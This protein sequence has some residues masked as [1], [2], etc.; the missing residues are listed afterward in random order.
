MNWWWGIKRGL[1]LISA[2]GMPTPSHLFSKMP[3]QNPLLKFLGSNYA[4]SRGISF[5]R[6]ISVSQ[7]DR[8]T[9]IR[10]QSL[11]GD[12]HGLAAYAKLLREAFLPGAVVFHL[13]LPVAVSATRRP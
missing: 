12:L 1:M 9:K 6:Q 10:R 5:F 13:S 8:R 11:A 2:V 3:H 7:L 4:T